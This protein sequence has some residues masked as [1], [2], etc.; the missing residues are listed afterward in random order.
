MPEAPA[1]R[2]QLAQLLSDDRQA[3]V[4][5][6]LEEAE[7]Q[8]GAGSPDWP[9]AL[10]ILGHIY[11][12]S[13]C[14]AGGRGEARARAGTRVQPADPSTPAESTPASRV[15]AHHLARCASRVSAMRRIVQAAIA[16]PAHAPN[17]RRCGE[18]LRV[19]PTQFVA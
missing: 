17:A 9:W 1:L 18:T 10:L 16:G 2:E 5:P 3:E 15:S 4:A 19:R 12:E 13:L 8:D 11:N 7:L 6:L 14:G